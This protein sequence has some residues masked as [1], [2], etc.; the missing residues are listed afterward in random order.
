MPDETL[1]SFVSRLAAWNGYK[2]ARRLCDHAGISFL[3][4]MRGIAVP[5]VEALAG[6]EEGQL[7]VAAI[8][9][10]ARLPTWR[11][12]ELQYQCVQLDALHYCPVCVAEDIEK[13]PDLPPHVA[14]YGRWQWLFTHLPVCHQHR[15]VLHAMPQIKSHRR[16][17]ACIFRTH[18]YS[19]RFGPSPSN[20]EL[21][22]RS[23]RTWKTDS[24]SG[25]EA[26]RSWTS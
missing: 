12:D 3:D 4:V 22:R 25:A 17:F 5:Q 6:M 13:R 24:G 14:A 21:E 18:L 16:D 10:S 23:K 15:V 2:T 8:D 1:T 19:L 9:T 26:T 20:E 11:G 7:H